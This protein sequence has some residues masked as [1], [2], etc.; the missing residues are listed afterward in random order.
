MTT[1]WTESWPGSNGDPW[2]ARWTTSGPSPSAPDIQSNLGRMRTGTTAFTTYSRAIAAGEAT[3]VNYEIL[4]NF[5]CD[6]PKKAEYIV[7]GVRTTN[8]WNGTYPNDGYF[9]ELDI[10]GNQ[11]FLRRTVS[12]SSSTLATIGYTF[13]VTG[14]T[15]IRLQAVGSAIRAKIWDFDIGEPSPWDTEVTNSDV[16]AAG[17]VSCTMQSGVGSVCTVYFGTMT[18]TDAAGAPGT[19]VPQVIMT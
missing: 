14:A 18:V 3:S 17:Y 11:Y 10:N 12:G 9:V 6:N 19:F 1:L 2:A 8:A 7:L 13:D 4:T 5:S 15:N 16:T